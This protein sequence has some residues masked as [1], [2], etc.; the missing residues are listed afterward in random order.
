VVRP[1]PAG[2]MTEEQAAEADKDVR[3]PTD[4]LADIAYTPGPTP[5]R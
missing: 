5:D 1:A 4:E 2:N 3:W